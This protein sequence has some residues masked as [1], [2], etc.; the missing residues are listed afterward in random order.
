MSD[1]AVLEKSA[2]ARPVLAP[3]ALQH[4]VEQFLY[5]EAAQIDEGRFRPW[6]DLL[7]DDIQYVMMTNTLAQT[8]DRRKGIHLPT[9]YIYNEDKFQLER[10]VAR[11]ET[12]NAWA[13]EPASRTRHILTNI[14]ILSWDDPDEIEVACNYLLHRAAKPLD[15]YDFIGTRRDRLRRTADGAGWQVFDRR[16]ELDQFVLLAPSISVFF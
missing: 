1:A 2:P 12:G 9:T 4:E 14:R 11:L 10:R 3:L 13:E 16:I 7:A 5:F 6:L 8:R 15:H